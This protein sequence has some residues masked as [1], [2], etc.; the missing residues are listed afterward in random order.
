MEA[1]PIPIDTYKLGFIGAGKLAE[2]IARGVVQSG[3]LPPHRI[4][5]AIHV[6]SSRRDAFESFGVKVLPNNEAVQFS[7][8]LCSLSLFIF[9]A[10]DR[11]SVSVFLLEPLLLIEMIKCGSRV[12]VSW[13]PGC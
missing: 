2:S 8:P 9:G 4:Y 6:N 3:V 13:K 1:I 5:T 12:L 7:L 10:V 11:I